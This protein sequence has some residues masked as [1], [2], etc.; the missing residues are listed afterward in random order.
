[1]DA[2]RRFIKQLMAGET[3][4]QVFLV[5]DKDMRTT[6]T[7]GLYLQCTLA[8]RTGVIPARMWQISE[9]IYNAIPV[10]GFLQVKG[11]TEEYRGSLQLII[12]ACRPK[13]TEKIDLN[14]FLPVTNQDV[15]KMWSELLDF[16]RGI[17]DK[18]LKL[19]IKK[20]VEDH[21]LVAAFKRSPAAM[22]L[23]HAFIGGLLEHTLMMAL[24][25]KSCFRFTR[26]STPTWPSRASS[27]MT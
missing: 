21:D 8:D 19:L 24:L 25:P 9:S 23:H 26:S 7:G 2:N 1:M 20:F 15:E 6:K 13:S 18:Y 16:T 10:E 5:C 14:D 22:Q 12:D 3:I 4:D 27:C 17:K 11:R